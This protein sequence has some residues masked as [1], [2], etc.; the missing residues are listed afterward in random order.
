MKAAGVDM[1]KN[2]LRGAGNSAGPRRTGEVGASG[3]AGKKDQ[4]G[5]AG[6]STVGQ[7]VSLKHIYEIA[8]IKASEPR[9]KG[10]DLKGIVK[11][12][13]WQAGSMGVVIV[14]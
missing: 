13:I 7:P 1:V 8:K 5:N 9:M 12:V 10:K 4:A 14:P 6:I 3:K 11:N 2:R